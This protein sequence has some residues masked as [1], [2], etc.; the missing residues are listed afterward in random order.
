MIDIFK[1]IAPRWQ[2]ATRDY[3]LAIWNKRDIITARKKYNKQAFLFSRTY[4]HE[5]EKYYREKN[6]NVYHGTLDGKVNEW[7]MEQQ[8]LADTLPHA[9]EQRQN[10]IVQREIE[11]YRYDESYTAQQFLNKIYDAKENENVYKIFSFKDNFQKRSEQIGDENAY[12]LG[13]KINEGIIQQLSDRYYWRTQ[14]DRRV[15]NTHR[16]LGR[17][18]DNGKCFLFTDPPTEELLSGKKHTGNP[19]TAWGCR[20]WAELAPKRAKVLRH[21]IVYEKKEKR[22]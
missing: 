14:R 13:T 22:R 3:A 10:E 8:A 5:L 7:L 19:G 11:K 6:I 2:R 1:N 20:C 4:R 16:Q 15:R 12:N 9:I 21:H 17:L 18:S